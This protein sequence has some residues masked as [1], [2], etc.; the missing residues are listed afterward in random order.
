MPNK[1]YKA[2]MRRRKGNKERDKNNR[3]CWEEARKV[4]QAER[5]CVLS[6]P[7]L[8]MLLDQDYR[9]HHFSCEQFGWRD[10]G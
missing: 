9:R 5:R 7:W 2:K 10:V 6:I 1:N 3:S 8:G 4:R